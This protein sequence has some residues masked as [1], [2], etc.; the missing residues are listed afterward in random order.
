MTT[1]SPEIMFVKDA[2]HGLARRAIINAR[3]S[4]GTARALGVAS[5]A[6]RMRGDGGRRTSATAARDAQPQQARGS[7]STLAF[8]LGSIVS[9]ALGY[10]LATSRTDTNKTN[11][12]FNTQYGTPEDFKVAIKEL[13]DAFKDD[14]DA[15][16]TDE[17]ELERHGL[18]N[19]G[20]HPGA[21]LGQFA[22]PR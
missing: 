22:A 16:S 10:Y 12:D 14:E 19:F 4:F 2:S 21:C 13:Q 7:N 1:I 11:T 9:G 17:D 5:S 3:S 15:V 6:T 18:A 20:I 8:A